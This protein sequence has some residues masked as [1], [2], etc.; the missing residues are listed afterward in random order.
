MGFGGKASGAVAA[1]PDIGLVPLAT[2]VGEIT[3]IAS[4]GDSRLLLTLQDGQIAIWDGPKIVSPYFLDIY[5]PVYHGTDQ[6]LLGLAFHPQYATNGYF[7]V[8]YT[9]DPGHNIVARYQV[10]ADP[11]VADPGSGVILM[12][13][14]NPTY[15]NDN[16][17][18][19]QFGPD[20]F[21]Y[22]GS[23]DSGGTDDPA[24]N[25]QN[26]LVPL[27][28]VLRIDVNFPT[29]PFW[30]SPPGNPY[31]GAG[32]PGLDE[33]WAIGLRNP[34]FSFDRQTG[35]LWIGDVGQTQREEID[36]QPSTSTGGENYGWKVMEGTLCTGDSVTT[37]SVPPPACGSAAFTGPIYEY[38]HSLGNCSVIGGYVYRGSAISGLNGTYIYGDHCSGTLWGSGQPFTATLPNLSTFGE[39]A[40]GELYAATLTGDF[41]RIVDAETLPTRTPTITPTSTRTPTP[42]KTVSPTATITPT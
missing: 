22:I 6:G 31:T 41:Y 11:N 40:S 30:T 7:F 37:C 32:D 9:A 17:G 25:A 42:T 21:L 29:A 16:G 14:P 28:K 38:D 5:R 2:N 24:C 12:T 36:F 20:G 35:D 13:I 26:K 19:L 27:G 18:Q 39:D 3:S 15:N 4:A 8:Y 10:S 33:I 1:S 23:G 34:R